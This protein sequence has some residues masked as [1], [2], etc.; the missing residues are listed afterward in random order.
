MSSNLTKNPKPGAYPLTPERWQDFETLFGP[1]GACAGC[2]CMWWRLRRSEWE[3]QKGEGNKQAI[4]R[5]VE[6]GEVA[7]VLAYH[8]GSP[9]GWCSLAPRE[10]FPVL[11]RSRILKPVDDRPVWSV[12]CLFIAK[13]WRRQGITL[14]LLNAAIE[15]ARANGAKIL[16]A[17]PIDTSKDNYPAVFASTGFYSTFQKAGFEECARRSD[18]RPIMRYRLG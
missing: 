15:Y 5:I 2:W 8:E 10:R 11:G 13:D 4:R 3:K 1:K 6:S 12:T 18:T 16:E 14:R 17:Y 9:V 7:G